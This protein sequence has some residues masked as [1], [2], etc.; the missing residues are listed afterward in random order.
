[1]KAMLRDRNA[2]AELE[3][4]IAESQKRIDF[5]EG[6]MQKLIMKKAGV[7]PNES[8]L[9][10]AAHTHAHAHGAG[11]GEASHR[12]MTT[13]S[14]A[15]SSSGVNRSPSR[16]SHMGLS[17]STPNA[18][19]TSQTKSPNGGMGSKSGSKIW[20]KL[21]FKSLAGS[22]TTL[23]TSES[24]GSLGTT[25][26]TTAIATPG[27]SMHRK[28]S[29]FE[30]SKA[31]TGLTPEKIALKL[32]DLQQKLELEQRVKTGADKLAQSLV[33]KKSLTPYEKRNKEEVEQKLKET[34]ARITL[35][36]TAIQRYSAM[37]VEGLANIDSNYLLES[38]ST[39]HSS[40]H[41]MV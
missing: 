10:G 14:G 36:K 41:Y 28:S 6:E 24:T 1:M 39:M 31:S 18:T 38:A 23:P 16:L 12:I 5:L 26:T 27:V 22:I 11:M 35:L 15:A 19:T 13:G 34:N 17:A 37:H 29:I 3:I 21:G 7:D 9:L 20:S 32:M 4:S 30:A 25:T 33:E 8:S 2:L 40:L